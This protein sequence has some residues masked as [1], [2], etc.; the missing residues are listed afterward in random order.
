MQTIRAVL[1]DRDGV[2]N[3]DSPNYILSPQ[4]WQAI[5]GS[6]VAIAKLT[7]NGIATALCSNQSAVGRGMISTA[8][9]N[10]IQDKMVQ[11]IEDAGGRLNHMAYCRHLPDAGCDC[12]K[13]K[14]GL[15]QQAL[16]A[17]NLPAGDDIL[18]I[19]DSL[20]DVQAA[21]AAGVQPV[22]VQTGYG[23]AISIA[24][25]ARSLCAKLDMKI[26]VYLNLKAAVDDIVLLGNC[27]FFKQ[28]T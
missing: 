19:G 22:L 16:A 1:L 7:Q 4:Q 20:K 3:H 25:Q 9:F 5:D 11:Q 15:L 23:D 18:M 10:D 13:P 12:R 21:L 2:I 14:A 17:L 24:K 6:L 27:C 28:L 26:N 8:V